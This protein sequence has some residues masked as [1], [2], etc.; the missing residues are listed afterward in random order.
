MAVPMR[1]RLIILDA[2]GVLWR[3]SE[4]VPGAS[5]FTTR[6]RAAGIRCVLL[7][8]NSN[9]DR[10]TYQAKCQRL[11]LGFEEAD[12][13]S[14]NYVAGIYFAQ[15]HKGQSVLVV[16]SEMLAASVA[17]HVPTVHAKRWLADHFVEED[18]D[19]SDQ[20]RVL[21][22]ARFDSVLVG[23]DFALSYSRLALACAAV[24]RGARL[25]AANYDLTYPYEA[26]LLLPGNGSMVQ[27]VEQVS[28]SQA[29]V[30]GKPGLFMLER[31]QMETG[32]ARED[33]LLVGDRLD[34]DIAMARAGGVAALLPLTGVTTAGMVPDDLVDV[35]VVAD[36]LEAAE[37]LGI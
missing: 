10:R 1:P 13:F 16:G 4:A 22:G 6:A 21:D 15:N 9:S 31:I 19:S 30:I 29:V 2:D 17:E 37:Q 25:V 14:T 34:T 3:G 18:L 24:Q 7:T 33:M 32:V 26:G 11:G 8:N 5:E 35:L 36:L 20:F 28:G 23:I 12:I 27:V